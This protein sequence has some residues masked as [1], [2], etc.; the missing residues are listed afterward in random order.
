V[1]GDRST[2]KLNFESAVLLAKPNVPVTCQKTAFSKNIAFWSWKRS[3][4]P[5]DPQFEWFERHYDCR[6]AE[7]KGSKGRAAKDGDAAP[8]TQ[9]LKRVR[10]FYRKQYESWTKD[11]E[12]AEKGQDKKETKEP[13]H[14]A[15]GSEEHHRGRADGRRERRRCH[16]DDGLAWRRR[17]VANLQFPPAR[18]PRL[19]IVAADGVGQ[20]QGR[21]RGHPKQRAGQSV[22]TVA[23]GTR[24]PEPDQA[25]RRDDAT[26]SGTSG[27][28]AGCR[29]PRGGQTATCQRLNRRSMRIAR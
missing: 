12:N 7:P 22:P 6:E 4:P 17:V 20:R 19:A 26:G 16:F 14:V 10:E 8:E 28:F 24:F 1:G 5:T 27:R 11:R 23:I 18:W 15:R 29:F 2:L 9:G 13:P 25:G 3:V 21:W